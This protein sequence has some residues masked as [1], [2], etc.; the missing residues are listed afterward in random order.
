MN[1][2]AHDAWAGNQRRASGRA[3]ALAVVA[4][5]ALV[6][7]VAFSA[8]PVANP[9]DNKQQ[10]PQQ[11]TGRADPG[12]HRPAQ[13][14]NVAGVRPVPQV[15]GSHPPGATGPLQRPVYGPRRPTAT[16]DATA[17]TQTPKIGPASVGTVSTMAGSVGAPPGTSLTRSQRAPTTVRFAPNFPR[18]STPAGVSGD[19]VGRHSPVSGVVGGPAEYDARKGAV[20][21]GTGA[22]RPF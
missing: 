9:A 2:V 22:K 8:P 12:T 15:R 1:V 3:H 10:A 14:H 7:G 6:F 18:P 19:V 13:K 4:M 16:A 5:L 11:S 17:F 20:I 21:N